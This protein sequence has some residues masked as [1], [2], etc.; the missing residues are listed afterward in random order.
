MLADC[1]MLRYAT[2]AATLADA[3]RKCRSTG[4]A[5]GWGGRKKETRARE[6]KIDNRPTD[7]CANWII[8]PPETESTGGNAGLGPAARAGVQRLER[9]QRR[10]LE[11]PLS[12]AVDAAAQRLGPADD[13]GFGPHDEISTRRFFLRA[14]AVSFGEIG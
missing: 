1:G 14:W 7:A 11:M 5:V 12:L 6:G 10:R 4:G 9:I 8:M 3:V 2:P 13:G